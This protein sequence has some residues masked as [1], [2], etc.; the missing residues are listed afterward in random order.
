M[1]CYMLTLLVYLQQG[2]IENKIKMINLANI[3]KE[4]LH[5]FQATWGISRESLEKMCLKT[6]LK[7]NKKQGFTLSL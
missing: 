1:V 5:I 3:N 2:N 4:N 6:I 7:V